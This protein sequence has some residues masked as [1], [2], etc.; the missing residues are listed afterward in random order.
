M[1]VPVSWL[2]EFVDLGDISTQ[3]LSDCLTFS[4]VEVEGI[5]VVGEGLDDIIVGEVLEVKNHPNAD[6]LRICTVSNGEEELQIVCGAPNVAE[7]MKV[8]LAQVGVVLPG[9]FRIK[10]ARIRGENSFGMLCSA[11]ELGLS[12]DSEGIVA[13]P[14]DAVPGAPLYSVT[15]QPETVLELEIT[16][17]RPD[18]LS[19]LGIAREFAALLGKPLCRPEVVLKESGGD[20]RDSVGVTVEAPEDCPRYTARMIRTVK[21]CYAPDWM[22]RRLELCG[23]RSVNCAV[24]IT[25]YVMLECGQPL[26]A[27]DFEKV[28]DGRIVVRLAK[29]AETIETIDHDKRNLDPDMLVIADA[30]APVAVAGVMGGAGSEID[31]DTCT[32]LL[33][34]ATFAPPSV[35]RTSTRMGLRSESSHRFERGVDP[36]IA[37]WAS[38]RAASLLAKYA[39]GAVA[40]GI[41]DVRSSE[42]EAMAITLNFGRVNEVIGID[43]PADE[44]AGILTSLGFAVCERN[45]RFCRVAV[46]SWRYDIEREA[47]LTEEVARMIGLERIPA[48][49]PAARVISGLDDLRIRSISRCRDSMIGLGAREVVHYSFLSEALLDAF[50]PSSASTRVRLP[51]PVSADHSVMRDTLMAQAVETLGRNHARQ[52]DQA[53]LFEIGRVFSCDDAAAGRISESDNLCIAMMGP[54]GRHSLDLRREIEP[55]DAFLWL[56]G[57]FGSLCSSLHCN[58]VDFRESEHETFESGCCASIE[59][60]GERCGVIGLVRSNI[61]HRWRVTVPVAVLEVSIDSILG[62]VFAL[63]TLKAVPAYPSMSRDIA[64]LADASVTHEKVIEIIWKDAPKELTDVSLFDIF[65][66]KAIEK[67]GIRSLA[68]SLTYLSHDR[69]L[70]DEAVNRIHDR[71]RRRL[72]DEL[73]IE[74]REG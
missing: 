53:V 1:K 12:K 49:S 73:N 3:G 28:R 39:G 14:S 52:V 27:F 70:T 17:N 22:R 74:I 50:S 16:W 18:C 66:S 20:I 51:N 45:S 67:D 21:N 6:R 4:G 63:P 41:I 44:A 15:G 62:A 40:P 11:S 35:K 43:V 8:P 47:D 26:H 64:F 54:V 31:D 69:T 58:N 38:K 2:R 60:G 57:L 37:D 9:D 19:I 33:E 59:V 32:V 7:G 24:D 65:K 30:V 42:P 36:E 29:P 25:N 55:E 48:G 23:V 34:S 61:R 5:E 56:K 13:L 46:P 68:Y 72:C 71:I 10:K